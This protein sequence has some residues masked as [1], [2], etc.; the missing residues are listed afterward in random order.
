MLLALSLKSLSK[1]AIMP[2]ARP[3][4]AR[5]D[6]DQATSL[7]S[8]DRDLSSK[9]KFGGDEQ[10]G[11]EKT[12]TSVANNELPLYDGERDRSHGEGHVSTAEDL[13]TQVIHVEDDPS[14]NPWTFRMFFLGDYSPLLYAPGS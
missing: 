6:T 12:D 11:T 5:Q 3:G 1:P 13:V 8:L 9:S 4:F 10:V 7:K 2:Q 14:L